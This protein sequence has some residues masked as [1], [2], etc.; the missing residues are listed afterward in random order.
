MLLSYV[1]DIVFPDDIADGPSLVNRSVFAMADCGAPD[2]IKLDTKG[3]VYAGW[4]VML[5]VCESVNWCYMSD[6]YDDRSISFDGVHIWNPHGT[7]LG[8]M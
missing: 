4:Y 7:L 2:G 1:Y 6:C 8:K 5:I 3:N